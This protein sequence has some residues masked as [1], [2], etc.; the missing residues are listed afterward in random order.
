MTNEPPKGIRA[1]MIG[2]Y[3]ADPLNNISFFESHVWPLAWK[4]LVF[5]LTMFHSIIQERKSYG[6]LG[7]N[8]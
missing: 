2:S 7:W 4:K 1:N 5:G 3:Q 6:P 8:I